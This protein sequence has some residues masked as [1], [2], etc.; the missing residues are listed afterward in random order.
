[1][2]SVGVVLNLDSVASPLG[3]HW[4]LRAGTKQFGDWLLKHL[5]EEAL[6]AAEKAAP[7]PFADHFPFS[8]FGVPAV[9]FMRPNMDGG[10]RW[11]HH[12]A[13]DH[14]DNVSIPE[15]GR[16][17]RAVAGVTRSLGSTSRWPF[18]RGLA[19]EQRA[20]TAR[21]AYELFG[22]KARG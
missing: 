4:V 17:V 11:Q 1:M 18:S 13:H 3:H 9:T 7:M 19:P 6:D 8:A 5:A 20:E 10:M 21:M 12:S 22:L 2:G 15:L 16:V 14:L